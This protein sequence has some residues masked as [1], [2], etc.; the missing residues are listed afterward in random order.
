M[1]FTL[2][3]LIASAVL[4]GFS[5]VSAGPHSGTILTGT[6]PGEDRPGLVYLPPG[7]T[8]AK[9]YPV[10]YLLHGMPGSPSEY[11]YG[12]DL[13][14]FAGSAITSGAVKPFIGVMPAAGPD[15]GYN[16]EWAGPW[17]RNLVR[18]VVPWVDEHLPAIRARAGRILVGLSAGGYGAVDI[19]LRHPHLFG[20]VESWGGYFHPLH[21]GP[22]KHAHRS[23][24]HAHD[25]TLLARREAAVL[26]REHIKFFLS[27]GPNHSHWFTSAQTFAFRRELARL[28]IEATAFSYPTAKGQW[29]GQLRRGLTWAL[30]TTTAGQRG[31][32]HARAS[33]A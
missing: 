25:P 2:A 23:A 11:V 17:E 18:Q 22:L 15:R 12:A 20:I 33:G 1:Q 28:G 14:P 27:T 21:D 24:L 6:I 29:R 3:A 9:R 16:G 8:P 19:A 32:R 31:S 30:A 13:V 5:A 26:R 4:P 7:F 10:V